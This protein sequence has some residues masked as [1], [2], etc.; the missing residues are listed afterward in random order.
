MN[1]FQKNIYY[2]KTLR[3]NI[4]TLLYKK[5]IMFL[6]IST[7]HQPA[8]DLGYLLHKH[9]ARFQTKELSFGKVHIFYPEASE[10]I[11]TAM[12]LL[13]INAINLARKYRKT[14]N[15]INLDH[16][17]NDRP[18]VASSFMTTAISKVLGS[19]LN[20]HCKDRPE[21]ADQAI[22]LSVEI[23]MIKV[24][25]GDS[26]I[27]S[28]F[29][30]LGYQVET[31]DF[32]LDDHFPEWGMSPYFNIQLSQN[33]SLQSLLSHLY[34]LIPVM[35]NNKHYYMSDDEVEKV[36]D[37]GK[38][39]L[40][41]HPAKEMITKRYFRYKKSYAKTV[42]N[43]LFDEEE[44]SNKEEALE[45]KISLHDLRLNTIFE[46]IKETGAKSVIDLGCGEGKLL[47]RLLAG[48]QFEKITGLDISYQSLEMAKKRLRLQDIPSY[49]KQRIELIH[50]ALNYRDQRMEGYDAA[51]LIEVIEHMDENRLAAF[52]KVVFQHAR[53]KTVFITTPN[54]EY[55]VLF[56]GLPTG[57]FR[58]NDHRFEWTRKEFEKWG[59][60]IADKCNYEV[61]F[62][63]L[64]P[65]DEKHGAPSQLGIFK[66]G[67]T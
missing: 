41:Q 58:H 25:G 55:N 15:A 62:R 51:A 22:P 53:P 23:G 57:K 3:S 63:P 49:Q 6:K 59:Q 35:D 45:K 17:V 30:P 43:Q 20:G 28:L 48:A 13:D 9:P 21:L 65:E 19:A 60:G 64:G 54:R 2:A 67:T 16:Y 66:L 40:S 52:E 47:K 10:E 14:K 31:K 27:R 50:G 46:L 36:L 8:T 32:P 26:L 24:N 18:Y 42:M 5:K 37:K 39:W 56:E 11:C 38:N 61:E 44:K 1:K 33:I 7:T 29:R 12:I 4:V 34:L